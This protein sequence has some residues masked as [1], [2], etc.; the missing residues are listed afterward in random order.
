MDQTTGHV[1]A[2]ATATGDKENRTAITKLGYFN[3]PTKSKKQT[4][5]GGV[6]NL[7]V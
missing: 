7:F 6:R 4:G 5:S 2:A 1:L 3:Y